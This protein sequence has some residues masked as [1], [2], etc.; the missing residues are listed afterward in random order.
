MA[1]AVTDR[2]RESSVYTRDEMR[3]QHS[4]HWPH[5]H[6]LLSI[7]SLAGCTPRAQ[8]HTQSTHPTISTQHS[9]TSGST[10]AQD[11]R[12]NDDATSPACDASAFPTLLDYSDVREGAPFS[13]LVRRE[14]SGAWVP[15][16]PLRMP[17]HHA[18]SL[19]FE[20][21]LDALVHEAERDRPVLVLAV[22]L[23]RRSIE[24][25]ARRHAWFATYGARVVQAVRVARECAR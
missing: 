7:L 11:A 13:L 14:P 22:G 12:M 18:S 10:A 3:S 23:G 16:E 20:P 21:A 25:D 15:A 5:A 6:T 19:V 9:D 1:S 8:T 2:T 4:K 17:M 24:H